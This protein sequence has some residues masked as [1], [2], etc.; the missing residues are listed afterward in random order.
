LTDSVTDVEASLIF[1]NV[2][3]RVIKDAFKHVWW[4]AITYYHTQMVKQKMN[5]KY[6]QNLH[7]TKEEYLQVSVDWLVKDPKAWDWI[8]RWWASLE[9]KAISD[10]NHQNWKSK[11]GLHRYRAD[12]H[13]RKTRRMI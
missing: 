9:F 2:T 7:M 5:T 6:A 3:C 13:V 12:G 10:T 4:Q 11:L 1:N 8:C